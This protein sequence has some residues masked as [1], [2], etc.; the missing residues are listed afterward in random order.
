MVAH[1]RRD[2]PAAAER[3]AALRAAFPEREDAYQREIEALTAAGQSEA[4]DRLRA[5][6]N[7]K[8]ARSG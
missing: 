1:S 3:W 5:E 6:Q 2:W 7:A 8:F 4:A